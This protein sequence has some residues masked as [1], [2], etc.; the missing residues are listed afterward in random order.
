MNVMKG[1]L[2]SCAAMAILTLST[3]TASAFH[4]PR[5]FVQ[6][7]YGY[8][9]TY[10]VPVYQP[11]YN[12]YRSPAFFGGGYNYG[13]PMGA[14]FGL[15]NMGLYNQGMYNYYGPAYGYRGYNIGFGFY[16]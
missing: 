7:G 13:Y 2:V 11:Y 3:S 8:V 6:P 10:N 14:N 9:G 12:Y 1:M 16:R 4:R 15:Y 5:V